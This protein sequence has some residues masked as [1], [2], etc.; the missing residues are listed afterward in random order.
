MNASDRSV[1][2]AVGVG[3]LLSGCGGEDA[4]GSA[5]VSG[6]GPRSGVCEA[7]ETGATPLLELGKAYESS[8][9]LWF[10]QVR[11]A[12]IMADRRLVVADAGA[13]GRNQIHVFDSLGV[14]VTSLGREGSGPGEFQSI[15]ELRRIGDSLLV[16]DRALARF[17]LFGPSGNLLWTRRFPEDADR[18]TTVIG[19]F[20]GRTVVFSDAHARARRSDAAVVRDTLQLMA[21]SIEDGPR[22]LIGV[23]PGTERYID[24]SQAFVVL[25]LPFGKRASFAAL[26][27]EVLVATGDEP[28]LQRVSIDGELMGSIPVPDRSRQITE[29][30]RAAYRDYWMNDQ[31]LSPSIVERFLEHAGFP[32]ETPPYGRVMVDAAGLI[33]IE[34]YHPPYHALRRYT[35]LSPGGRILEEL[36]VPA[37]LT[38]LD[39]DLHRVV[40][41]GRDALDVETVVVYARECASE[42]R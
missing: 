33:W 8:S 38:L 27:D 6:T 16:V 41:R 13:T 32:E 37:E 9:E 17:T 4:S 19:P 7:T 2:L 12:L 25:P 28:A 29:D 36:E 3:L 11:R 34:E 10:G 30:M 1:L 31:A 5:T 15:D 26:G 20:E 21:G 39:A 23:F 22:R 14:F 42:P 24:L 35:V 18:M 40:M